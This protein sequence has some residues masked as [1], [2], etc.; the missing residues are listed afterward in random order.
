[1]HQQKLAL[2]YQQ[3]AKI[4]RGFPTNFVTTRSSAEMSLKAIL[5][6]MG[7]RPGGIGRGRNQTVRRL[8]RTLLPPQPQQHRRYGPRALVPCQ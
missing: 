7:S 1:M 2:C 5:I 6:S 4:H 8:C 3:G